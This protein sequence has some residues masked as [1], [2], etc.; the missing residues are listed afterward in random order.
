MKIKKT[1]GLIAA[2]FTPLKKDGSLN[3]PVIDD[4]ATR[5]KKDHLVG[6]FVGGTTGE[7]MLLDLEERKELSETWMKHR[8]Q[9]FKIMFHVGSTSYKQSQ[10]LT[11]HAQRIGADAVGCIGPMF[12][13]PMHV[14]DLVAYCAKVASAAPD[15]PFYYYHIPGISGIDFNM[16]EFLKE[17]AISFD[18]FVG[19]KYTYNDL[20]VM[21][22]CLHYEQGKWDILHGADELLLAGLSIGVRGA[23]GSTYN[24]MASLNYKLMDSFA[25]GDLASARALQLNTISVIELLFRYGGPVSAGKAIMKMIGLDCGPLRLPAKTLSDNQQLNFEKELRQLGFLKWLD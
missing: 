21:I 24:Y 16:F 14:S 18:N 12:L 5:L 1:E 13:K 17:A 22:Q 6:V 23:I 19:I 10:E 9:N 15:M 3:L 20:M 4:Y 11:Q 25:K 8:D 7:G 2:P